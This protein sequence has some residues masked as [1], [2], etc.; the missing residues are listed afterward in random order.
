MGVKLT[1]L[2]EGRAITLEELFEK[3]ISIDA[4]NWIYQFL[5]IIRQKDGQPL[6]DSQNRVTS[7]FAGLFYRTL[8]LLEAGVKPIYVFDGEPPEFKKAVAAKRRDIRAEAVKEWKAALAKGEYAEARKYAMR[9]STITD[10]IIQDCKKLLHAMGVP[11]VEAPNEG[12]AL[13]SVMVRKNDAYAVATQDYDS[14]LFGAPRLIR[15]LSITGKRKRGKDYIDVHPE[16]IILDEALEKLGLNQSQ[17]II[18][19]IL[20][21]TDYNPDGVAGYG[22]KRAL[23]LVR[24]KK[25]LSSVLKEIVWDFS[26]SAEEIFE[27]FKNPT[28]SRYTIEFR[29]LDPEAVKKILCDEHDFSIDRIESALE[30]FSQKKGGQKSL[31]KWF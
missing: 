27:F 5:S 6:L 10:E 9:S 29:E 3:R 20:S 23:Q 21:G 31:Q 12:E 8:K 4:F 26:V 15:N 24:E 7:H 22:P 1:E 16:L 30:K 19:G 17:L 25:T 11:Y 18:L 13:C 2:V 28:E 14:L